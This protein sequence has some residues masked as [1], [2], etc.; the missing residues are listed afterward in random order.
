[1]TT[2][3]T[4]SEEHLQFDA[5]CSA[6]ADFEPLPTVVIESSSE[7]FAPRTD[8]DDQPLDGLILAGLVAPS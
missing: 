1:M 8:P 2:P 4:P 3:Q 5:I 7:P 6:V